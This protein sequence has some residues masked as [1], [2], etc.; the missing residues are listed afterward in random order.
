MVIQF[1]FSHLWEH[2]MVIVSKS[3]SF[4]QLSC[5]T[6]IN[7]Y[8]PLQNNSLSSLHHLLEESF[9]DFQSFCKFTIQQFKWLESL[10]I[11]NIIYHS[12]F[13]CIVSFKIKHNQIFAIHLIVITE[14]MTLQVPKRRMTYF[15]Y[16]L[17]FISLK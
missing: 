15:G 14:S 12:L 7:P 16:V 4:S 3:L 1:N 6:Y 5:T 9:S 2:C 11:R 13:S 17:F 10:D 8:T